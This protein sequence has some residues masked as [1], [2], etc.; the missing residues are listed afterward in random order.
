MIV[1]P[2]MPTPIGFEW[3]G[4]SARASSS[5]TIAWWLHVRPRPPYSSGHVVPARPASRS[6]RLHSGPCSAGRFASSHSRTSVRK[7]ASSGVSR[8]FT[9]S[10]YAE[11]GHDGADPAAGPH[12]VERGGHVLE[13]D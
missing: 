3:I 9:G 13:G 10:L 12:V 5:S 4:A 2:A 7:A 1:G 11:T 6:L 8:R